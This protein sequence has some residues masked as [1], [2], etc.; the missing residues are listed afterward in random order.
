MKVFTNIGALP[1]FRN[2]VITIGSFDGVHSGHMA[3]IQELFKEARAIDGD[4]VLITFY[5]HP[6][7]II[8]GR[9]PV[10]VLN[11]REEKLMLFEK[12]GLPFIVE[13]PFSKEFA[14]QEA[15]VYIQDFLVKCFH[16]NTI[17]IGYDHKYGR[18]RKGDY[19]MLEDAGKKYGFRV[20]EISVHLLKSAAISSTRIRKALKS[21]DTDMANQLLGYDY[22]FTGKVI[23]GNQLGRKLGYP[24]ANLQIEDPTKLIPGN[25][26]YAVR[27]KL[28]NDDHIMS[29]MMSIGTRPTIDG[30]DRTIEVNI[31]DFDKDIYDENLTVFIKKKLR[32][33][34]RF[35][36]LEA[37]V[38]QMAM[39]K[40]ETLKTFNRS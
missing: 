36:S 21:G 8:S 17:I 14:N 9:P 1:S 24:T 27:C 39:D 15:S 25:S 23:R 37:L 31:F 19:Q 30:K 11:T 20:K 29:G 10:D 3:I 28:G 40:V 18:D 16:P 6:S 5:P 4:P 35:S 2:A 22:F 38:E 12:A 13:V 34:E 33:E 32:D 26:V 7:Q